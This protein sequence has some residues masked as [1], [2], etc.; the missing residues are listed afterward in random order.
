MVWDVLLAA[1][2]GGFAGSAV[3][4]WASRKNAEKQIEAQDDRRVGEIYLQKKVEA[5]IEYHSELEMFVEEIRIYQDQA[6]A[7]ELS[8][9]EW[10]EN[11]AEMY[12]SYHESLTRASIFLSKKQHKKLDDTLDPFKDATEH[13]RHSVSGDLLKHIAEDEDKY[14]DVVDAFLDARDVVREEIQR[15][16]DRLE[17]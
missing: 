9:E 8:E 4:A 13:V 14:E 7:G 11:V 2:L 17:S 5:L 16:I 1:A 10:S 15:G 3:Q 12:N 6:Y